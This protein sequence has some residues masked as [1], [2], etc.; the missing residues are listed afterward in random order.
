MPTKIFVMFYRIGNRVEDILSYLQFCLEQSDEVFA[1]VGIHPDTVLKT[2]EADLTHNCTQPES[3]SSP[4]F[5]NIKSDHPPATIPF[6][7]LIAQ[8]S[9]RLLKSESLA[10]LRRYSQEFLSIPFHPVRISFC[11]E[12]A[13]NRLHPV[14]QVI[15]FIG[16][17][18][19]KLDSIPD[20]RRK[21]DDSC[22][23]DRCQHGML[24]ILLL[25]SF[26]RHLFQFPHI[27]MVLPY[28]SES[29]YLFRPDVDS[30]ILESLI[31]AMTTIIFIF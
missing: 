4:P 7:F 23:G 11:D 20:N 28:E 16:Q 14:F 13:G 9:L 30:E 17:I 1:I 15:S 8:R 26:P 29:H 27:S 6:L 21:S 31:V 10:P 12:P 5:W 22:H 2:H 25:L 3:H 24:D 19:E 18:V